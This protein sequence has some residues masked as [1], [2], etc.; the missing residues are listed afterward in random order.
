MN[1]NSC[2]I[3]IQGQ[4]IV[5][6]NETQHNVTYSDMI[7]CLSSQENTVVNEISKYKQLHCVLS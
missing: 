4:G 3:C 5:S 1:E 7:I 2:R 6:I